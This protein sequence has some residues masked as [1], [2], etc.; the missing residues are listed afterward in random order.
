MTISAHFVEGNF[1]NISHR[2]KKDVGNQPIGKHH[3]KQSRGPP[4]EKDNIFNGS[5]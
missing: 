1:L 4:L 5:F 3:L 2:V